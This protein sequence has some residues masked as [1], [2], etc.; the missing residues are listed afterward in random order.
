M[1]ELYGYFQDDQVAVNTIS[2]L[3]GMGL[4]EK[5]LNLSLIHI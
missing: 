4:T 1:K 5:E 2:N 3:Q